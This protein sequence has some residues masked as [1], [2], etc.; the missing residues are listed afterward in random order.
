MSYSCEISFKQISGDDVYEFLQKFKKE[1]INHLEEI[2]EDNFIY[3]PIS[4]KIFKYDDLKEIPDALKTET[5]EWAKNN[6]FKFR[7]FYNKELQLLGVYS[8]H[9]SVQ[10]LFDKTVYFQNSSDQ[11]YE[12]SDWEGIKIFENI[13]DK[14]I[15]TS[16]EDIK[17]LY[18]E[19]ERFDDDFNNEFSDY[20]RKEYAYKEIWKHFEPTLEDDSSVLHLSLFGYY[21]FHPVGKFCYYVFKKYKAWMDETTEKIEKK[22]E[23]ITLHKPFPCGKQAEKMEK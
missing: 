10:Y 22:K 6:I 15:N 7:W 11:D 16:V 12:R 17:K 2:A 8:V 19:D 3:S 21:D 20:L 18:D 13:F 4:K 9:K 14:W 23:K 5:E 1:N